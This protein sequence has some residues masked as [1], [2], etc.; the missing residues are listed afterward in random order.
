MIKE[1]IFCGLDIGSQR[2]KAA[3]IKTK[4]PNYAELLGVYE[5]PTRGFKKS[6]ISDLHDLSD[7]VHGVLKGLMKATGW[8]LKD[9][10]LGIGGPLIECRY[11][12][13]AIPLVDKVS[14]VV[15]GADLKKVN[16]QACLLGV[17]IEEEILHD[18]PQHYL[19]DDIN[20]ALN[21]L[22]LYGRK[23]SVTSLLVLANVNLVSNI[24]KAVNR[25]GFEVSN[26][27][28]TS[29]AC[30]EVSLSKEA[31]Q[32][33]CLLVD[34]G[35][36][37][38][39]IL[40]IKDGLLKQTDVIHLGGD[41]FTHQIAEMLNIPFDLA[42]EIKISHAVVRGEA[43]QEEGE[44]LIKKENGY[45]PVKRK[46]ICDAIEPETEKLIAHIQN[47]LK[48]SRLQDK[49]QGGIVLA[50]GAALLPG[51]IEHVERAIGQPVRI[52]KLQIQAAAVNHAAVFMPAIGLAYT[53]FGKSTDGFLPPAVAGGWFN[54]I[55]NR[56]RDLYE[57]YF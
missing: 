26:V 36:E 4:K 35:A 43:K 47:I 21:P 30:A 9:I 40:F 57:E 37:T 56:I 15:T 19:V 41:H 52:G 29:Y 2:T 39:G 1:K 50:G 34:M 22:G 33:G 11:G 8:R 27:F 24:A 42:E 38:T 5:E 3:L 13:A 25:A 28:F 17:K 31:R 51:L 55:S 44:I 6:S 20:R 48:L 23:L 14:K 10:Q 45:K 12:K 49:L 53:G 18:F 46:V 32:R 7:S 54:N 16:K